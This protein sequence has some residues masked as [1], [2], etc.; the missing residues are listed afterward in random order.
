MTPDNEFAHSPELHL[1]RL[2]GERL[3]GHCKVN[4]L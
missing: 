2:L 4:L 3:Q 1:T